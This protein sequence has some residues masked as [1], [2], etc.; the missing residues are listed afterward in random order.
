VQAGKPRAS[1]KHAQ[2][3]AGEL[4]QT[5]PPRRKK[6]RRA[7]SNRSQSHAEAGKLRPAGPAQGRAIVRKAE[8]PDESGKQ[9]PPRPSRRRQDRLIRADRKAERAA[10][11]GIKAEMSTDRGLSKTER[12]VDQGISK[13]E[14]PTGPSISKAE[15]PRSR[16]SK[17]RGGRK[18][19]PGCTSRL[20]P[21]RRRPTVLPRERAPNL[22][23]SESERGRKASLARAF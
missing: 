8:Y 23:L 18:G 3:Q 6:A 16:P 14:R 12:A 17:A 10:G 9:P 2:K 15:R 1:W 20:F 21:R 5:T 4:G 7:S 22:C 13:A 19:T 11:Q